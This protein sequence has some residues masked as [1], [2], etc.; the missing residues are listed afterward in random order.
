MKPPKRPF[1][2][3]FLWAFVI[4]AIVSLSLE[5]YFYG[6]ASIYGVLLSIVAAFSFAY[7]RGGGKTSY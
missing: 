7:L 1:A 5:R 3:Y 2:F 4:A 6:E